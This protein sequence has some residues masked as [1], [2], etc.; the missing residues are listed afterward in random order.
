VIRGFERLFRFVARHSFFT[1]APDNDSP[2]LR[3]PCTWAFLIR[4]LDSNLRCAFGPQAGLALG[5]DPGL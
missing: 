3:A 5:R 4:L 2:G 1:E